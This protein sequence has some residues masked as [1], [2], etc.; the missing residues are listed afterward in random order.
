MRGKEPPLPLLLFPILSLLTTATTPLANAQSTS[1]ICSCSPTAYQFQ[2]SL[3]NTCDSSTLTDDQAGID[4]TLCISDAD[5]NA[6]GANS[7]GGRRTTRRKQLKRMSAVDWKRALDRIDIGPHLEH[8][9]TIHGN[10]DSVDKQG[11][12][13]DRRL[14]SPEE[15][16]TALESTAATSLFKDEAII[17]HLTS[18]LFLEIDST[19]DFDILNQDSTYFQTALPT[20][21]IINYT[22][23]SSNLNASLPIEDQ[24]EYVP[25]GVML[26]MFGMNE[27]EEVVQSTVAWSYGMEEC[28]VEPL[29]VGDSLGWIVVVS[30]IFIF[31]IRFFVIYFIPF[32][33]S[34]N[35]SRSM[36]ICYPLQNHYRKRMNTLL[37][38]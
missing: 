21:S 26:L 14:Q 9:A 3:N 15:N 7:G 30:F 28:G 29:G 35:D 32:H 10:T 4:D 12:H 38:Y 8:A 36:I 33:H 18:I 31:L 24:M 6:N 16:T 34:L 5:A 11:M 13:H 25:G 2:I 19:T 20:N 1:T 37:P 27:E 17:T 22:S 23:I